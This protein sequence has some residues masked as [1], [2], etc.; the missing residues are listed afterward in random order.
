VRPAWAKRFVIV[1]GAGLI[2]G[3]SVV[4]VGIAIYRAIAG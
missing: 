4:G 3:E 1:I 2:A